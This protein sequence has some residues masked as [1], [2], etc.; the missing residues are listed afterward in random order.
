MKEKGRRQFSGVPYPFFCA[1]NDEKVFFI[2]KIYHAIKLPMERVF[3]N[4]S[5]GK[6]IIP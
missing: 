6:Q 1:F 4:F 3:G 5:V 2:D